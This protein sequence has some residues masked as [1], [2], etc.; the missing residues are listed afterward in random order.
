MR[1]RLSAVSS[2]A[3]DVLLPI[4]RLW[5][6]RLLVTLGGHRDFVSPHGLTNDTLADALGLGEW[7]DPRGPEYDPRAVR[8]M[9]RKLHAASEHTRKRAMVPKRLRA[10]TARLAALV[11]LSETDCRVLE[12]AV[13]IHNERLLDD[14]ADYLGALSSAKVFHA[15]AGI[16]DIPERE[17]RTSLGAQGLLTRSGLLA[18]DRSGSHLL[19]AKLDLLSNNFAD[20]LLSS[21][22]DP[23]NLL[24]DTIAHS[25]APTVRTCDYAHVE[26][27]LAVL[28]AYLRHAV[29]TRRHGVN[30]LLYGDPGTGKTELARLMAQELGHP[31]F[32]VA[33]EDEDGNPI[34][35]ERRLRAFR[36]AQSFLAKQPV[37]LLFDEVE[38]VFNDADTA[39]GRRGTA[40]NRKGW[41]NRMLED[42][43][44]PTL[45]L[46]N[47]VDG[48]DP[49][50]IRRFDLVFELPIPARSQR[51]QILREHCAP[52]LTP[53][54]IARMAESEGLAP[55]VVTRAA[56][57]VDLIRE[58]LSAA[59]TA[60]AF[61]QMVNH[62]LQAQ[63]HRPLP[64]ESAASLPEVYDPD[65]IHA[66][67]DLSAVVRGLARA[68]SGRLCLYGPPGT[69]KTAYAHWLAEELRRPLLVRRASDLLSMWLGES[70]KQMAEAFR[71]AEREN[72]ILLIDEIDSFL[73]DRD[74]AHRSWEITLVN[75]ML[76]QVEA[77]LG[78]F[79]ASTNRIN[80]LDSAALRR[81]DLKVRFGFLRPEQ[82]Q[83]LFRRWCLTWGIAEP[84][85]AEIES[86]ARLDNLTPGDFAA[87][88]RRHR[89]HPIKSPSEGVAALM[90]E[91][92]LK[93]G[94]RSRIGF[95]QE[96]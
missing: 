69:G 77:F 32:E 93:D 42:N 90:E 8:Q 58:D 63:C 53:R 91:C 57:V 66:D 61:E 49:A 55:A 85:A 48:V 62:T 67:A 17:V 23:V 76:T 7:L 36:A 88:A 35:G 68:A 20:H 24:H 81:F 13:L 46:A 82:A 43:P 18:L 73:Q 39:L 75:E 4:I 37:L 33:A 12:F 50:F 21:D 34:H 87:V 59:Q 15:L 47:T 80:G 5:L 94:R 40:Q 54:S 28:R 14:T 60:A 89:F 79:I 38:D 72:A 71:R 92:S 22:A 84:G 51:E 95:K 78:I 16:L 3:Q 25:R 10:N 86:F 96:C 31:L 44:V 9:L 19:R 45:W 2:A 26:S 11:G 1:R 83:E 27:F 30:V 6:L 65:F 52:W 74:G 70:E 29:R 41:I 56:S 64:R